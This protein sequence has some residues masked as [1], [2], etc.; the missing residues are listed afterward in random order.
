M[1]EVALVAA[2]C[3]LESEAFEKERRGLG[4]APPSARP[5]GVTT[6]TLVFKAKGPERK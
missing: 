6:Q 4:R 2:Y 3:E 1:L 5:G